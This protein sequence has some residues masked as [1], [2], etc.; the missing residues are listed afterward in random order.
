[1][2]GQLPVEAAQENINIRVG[3][4]RNGDTG[5]FQ[6]GVKGAGAEHITLLPRA[7]LLQGGDAYIHRG[8]VV[9][10]FRFNAQAAHLFHIALHAPGGIIGE[11]EVAATHLTD[12]MQ[13]GND[14]VKEAVVQVNS[15]VHIQ[16]KQ[17]FFPQRG[18]GVPP[19]H[20]NTMLS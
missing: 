18:H 8:E 3:P 12:V 13:K 20:T 10:F 9:G 15:A 2:K 1:M 5:A 19:F 14:T 16:K 7:L 4:I 11:E 6:L 17:A